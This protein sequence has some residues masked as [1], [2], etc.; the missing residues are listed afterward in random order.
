M[1]DR[2]WLALKKNTYICMCA[3]ACIYICMRVQ[4]AAEL[5]KGLNTCGARPPGPPALGL[6][7]APAVVAAAADAPVATRRWQEGQME[8]AAAAAVGMK[9]AAGW[10][11]GWLRARSCWSSRWRRRFS[12]VNVSQQRLR[13]SQSTSV[14]FSLVLALLFWN[15]TSTC[16]GLRFS[17]LAKAAF[18]F[19]SDALC[20]ST[21][22]AK[23]K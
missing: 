1:N 13:I 3:H 16:L 12:S 6:L 17:C 20:T 18:C 8:S 2:A 4:Q 10:G 7:S 9:K 11:C 21:T 15:Q 19:C 14:C 5:V 22:R 23:K